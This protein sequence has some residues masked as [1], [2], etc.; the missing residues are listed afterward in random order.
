M[1]PISIHQY[2]HIGALHWYLVSLPDGSKARGD[3]GVSSYLLRLNQQLT[4]IALPVTALAGRKLWE[5]AE[6]MASPKYPD[7]V[8]AEDTE[9]IRSL[10]DRLEDTLIA[11]ASVQFTYV[12]TEKRLDV[13][14]LLENPGGLL[15]PNV[16]DLLPRVSRWDFWSASKAIAFELPTAAAFHLLRCTEGVLRHYY[17]C[18][19]KAKRLRP[20]KR[21]WGPMVEHLRK[22][23]SK[24][25]PR[26]LLDTLDR[27]RE[28]FRNP[29]N[30]PDKIYDIQEVQ[31]L[32]GLCVDAINR[33]VQP[34]CW[35]VPED[36][37]RAIITRQTA[38]N[39]KDH[40]E[41]G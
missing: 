10:A 34:P 24:P 8:T 7:L 31:D 37:L 27:I 18:N 14:K 25:P 20:D 11:E 41:G 16:L 21:M 12:V 35:Q 23:R 28:N 9:E 26:E 13:K 22:K 17:I 4:D 33:M 36:S 6:K 3:K 1:K 15:A 38:S 29:T 30:H 40:Q 5:L 2:I 19:V 39:I 32:F